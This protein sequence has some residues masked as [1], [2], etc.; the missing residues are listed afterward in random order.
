MVARRNNNVAKL[1]SAVFP[2]SFDPL[3][4]GHL[5]IIV[6][7]SKLFDRVYVAILTNTSKTTLFSA[8]ERLTLLR[9]VLGDIR[10]VELRLFSGLLVDF[11][12][13]VGTRV[14]VRGLRAVSDY[15]YETQIALMNRNL[16]AEIETFF[17][18]TREENS[19]ISSTVVKQVASL[20]GSVSKF[21]PPAV[22]RALRKKF[23][24]ERPAR[25]RR[26]R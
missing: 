18:I 11:A 26:A 17:L 24:G 12:K 19:F 16:C 10:G 5:D 14:I 9:E 3:T 23:A 20:G 1:T 7:T 4:N 21:V 2:G 8:D 13:S 22:E 6:R 25:V 15:D